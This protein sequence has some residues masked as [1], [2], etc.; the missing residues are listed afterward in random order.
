VELAA[1]SLLQQNE[2]SHQ[3]SRMKEMSHRKKENLSQTN[4]E[5]AVTTVMKQVICRVIA[6]SLDLMS[7][8]V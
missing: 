7:R 4:Q 6:R 1:K 2:K 5:T 8:T 3:L